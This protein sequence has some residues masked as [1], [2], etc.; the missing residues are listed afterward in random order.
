MNRHFLTSWVHSGI[1][2][3]L[4]V[5]LFYIYKS[6]GHDKF[7]VPAITL[8]PRS[9]ILPVLHQHKKNSLKNPEKLMI[10]SRVWV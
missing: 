6:V 10:L 3:Q 5:N 9:V 7:R 8:C 2:K 4:G 1:S